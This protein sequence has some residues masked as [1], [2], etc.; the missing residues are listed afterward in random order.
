[1]SKGSQ[2][3]PERAAKIEALRAEQRRKDRRRRWLIYGTVAV[4][5]LA[6]IVAVA[7]P[8]VGEVRRQRQVEAAADAPIEGVEE[9]SDP[10]SNHVDGTVDYA[11]IPPAGGDHSAILQNCGVYTDPVTDVNAVH[12]L[13]HGAVWITYSPDLADDQVQTLQGYAEGEDHLLVSPYEGL[14][15]PI[16]LSAWGVQLSVDDAAD[17]RVETF[18]T[19]YVQGEQTP[20]P[21]A[22]CSG[23]VGTPVS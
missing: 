3:V 4:V 23:G 6:L 9:F 19:K 11:V 18:L 8:L 7:V 17:D 16:V 20:E 13:E 10:T 12:S 22:P 2:R 21:G 14:D 15:G 5:C 1:M